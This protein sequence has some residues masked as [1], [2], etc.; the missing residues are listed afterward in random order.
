MNRKPS[1]DE[2]LL[3]N[4]LR[5]LSKQG[6]EIMDPAPPHGCRIIKWREQDEYARMYLARRRK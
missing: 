6:L 3:R 4:F 2:R 1:K 5:W